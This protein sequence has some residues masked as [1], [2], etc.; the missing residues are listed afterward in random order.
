MTKLWNSFVAML[1]DIS[2]VKDE[3]LY[4]TKLD[5]MCFD[6]TREDLDSVFTKDYAHD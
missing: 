1:A 4:W 6:I 2:H 3:Y 5:N